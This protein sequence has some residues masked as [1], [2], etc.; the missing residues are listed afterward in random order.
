[1]EI[2]EKLK[3]I[4]IYDPEGAE[5]L[6]RLLDR[7]DVLKEGNVYKEKFTERQFSIIFMRLLNS[8]FERARVLEALSVEEI[9][10]L[11]SE[12][13]AMRKDTIFLYCKELM[14]KNLIEVSG[15]RGRDPIFRRRA[16]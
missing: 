11:L 14:R 9:I 5:R 16:V 7:K 2:E 6:K 13:L 15:M 10:P 1:M 3:F 8:T 4:G 12:R